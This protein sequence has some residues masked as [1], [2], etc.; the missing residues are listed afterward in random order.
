[1]TFVGENLD[2]EATATYDLTLVAVDDGNL[3]TTANLTI[4]LDD[5]NDNHPEFA[6]GETLFS[7]REHVDDDNSR[8]LPDDAADNMKF[9]ADL[10]RSLINIPESLPIGSQVTQLTATDKDTKQFA[11]IRYNIVSQKSVGFHEDSIPPALEETDKFTI[12]AKTGYVIVSASLEPDKF[13]LLNV[14]ATDGGGLSSFAPVTIAVFDVNDHAPRFE[15]PV[16]SFEVVEGE[17]LV[18]EVGKVVAYDQDNG[19]NGRVKYQIIFQNEDTHNNDNNSNSNSDGSRNVN[20][21]SSNKNSNVGSINNNASGHDAFPFRIVETSGTVLATGSVDRE[22]REVYEFTVV[23]R[24]MGE[25]QLSSSVL[26]HI[27]IVDINDHAPIFYN[28]DDA[29]YPD[30]LRSGRNYTAIYRSAVSENSPRNALVAQI[31]ARDSDSNSSGNGILLYRLEGGED[32]FTIDSKNGTVFTVGAL[33]YEKRRHYNMTVVAQDLGTPPQTSTA[34][35]LVD[36]EDA[37]E[38]LTNRLF[39]REEYEVST[40]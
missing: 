25:P 8:M 14:S 32:K 28:Y 16:Y 13:Y 21:D 31:F 24:D 19:S 34:L 33:D 4:Y 40:L 6:H 12:E 30:E 20:H 2:R 37:E 7:A 11:A 27:D 22:E 1:M 39:D 17:Y 10:E 9:L 18:G 5:V 3:T 38:E 26:V 15:R 35:L 36:V 29:I 23:A